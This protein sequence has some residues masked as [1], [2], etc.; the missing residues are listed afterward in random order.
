ML[1][2][3][4]WTDS[5][6]LP[7]TFGFSKSLHLSF[8]AE[9]RHMEKI[10][11]SNLDVTISCLYNFKMSRQN[12]VHLNV[13]ICVSEHTHINKYVSHRRHKRNVFHPTGG[14]IGAFQTT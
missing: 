6:L 1:F 9:Q 2:S 10:V 5:E 7:Y 12:T 8:Q 3:K 4:T 13:N 14:G 11:S